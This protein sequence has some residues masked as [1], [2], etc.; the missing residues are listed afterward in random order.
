MTAPVVPDCLSEFLGD[1]GKILDEG[2]DVHGCEGFVTIQR[3]VEIVYI[4]LM[5]LAMVNF[6]GPAVEVRFE[7]IG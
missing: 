6:H 3:R 5:M 1:S 7:R 4:S 2:I